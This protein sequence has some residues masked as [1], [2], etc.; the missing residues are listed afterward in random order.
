M[1]HPCFGSI[2]YVCCKSALIGTQ[3]HI[4]LSACPIQLC[5][6]SASMFCAPI[7]SPVILIGIVLP[8]NSEVGIKWLMLSSVM[9]RYT[10]KVHVQQKPVQT[11]S[12]EDS[13]MKRADIS[14]GDAFTIDP[15]SL[16]G[17]WKNRLLWL[18]LRVAYSLPHWAYSSQ[19][20]RYC[21]RET[22]VPFIS[23]KCGKDEQSLFISRW[24]SWKRGVK[25]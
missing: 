6:F 25:E 17:L 15:S 14:C 12:V 13:E 4:C 2:G 21:Q 18:L 3:S 5:L 22:T 20:N 10:R 1:Q 16:I 23:T 7:I 8:L 24:Y 19:E 11:L 9:C